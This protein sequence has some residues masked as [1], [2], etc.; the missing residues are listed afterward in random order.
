[1]FILFKGAQAGRR[2]AQTACIAGAGASV[3][4]IAPASQCGFQSPQSV[5]N[6]TAI[7]E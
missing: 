3:A 7:P 2:E 4:S 1:M 6:A 5:Y